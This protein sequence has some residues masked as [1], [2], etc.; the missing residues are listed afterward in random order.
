MQAAHDRFQSN[1]EYVRNIAGTYTALTK[2]TTSALDLSDILR[3]ELVLTVSALDNFLHELVE[4]GI[5]EMY[6]GRRTPTNQ[7]LKY[8][9]PISSIIAMSSSKA[10]TW[11]RDEIRRQNGFKSFQQPAKFHDALKLVSTKKIWDE[12]SAELLMPTDDI[13]RTLDLIVDRRNQIA[14]QADAI[15]G[16]PVKKWPIDERMVND[17]LQFIEKLGRAVHNLLTT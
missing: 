14:H 8:S 5:M 17:S 15:P 7:F 16:Y 12:L 3:A 2:L 6:E 9:I 13:K 10:N 4:E 1:V 11:L